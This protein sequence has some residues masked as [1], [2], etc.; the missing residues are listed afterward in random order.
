MMTNRR[1]NYILPIAFSLVFSIAI[2]LFVCVPSAAYA[3]LEAGNTQMASSEDDETLVDTSATTRSTALN[4]L[5]KRLDAMRSQLYVY[6]DFSDSLNHFTQKSMMWGKYRNCVKTPDENCK[7]KPH[8]GTSCI[9][10]AHDTSATDWGGWEFYN[11]GGKG[12]DLTGATELRFWARGNSGG[13]VIDFF[14]AGGSG[15]KAKTITKYSV[16]LTKKWKQYTISL[17]GANLGNIHRGFGYAINYAKNRRAKTTFYLDD[18]MFV[19]NIEALQEAP[20][21]LRSYDTST[22]QTRNAAF[23][24]DNALTAMAFMSAGRNG[25]AAEI[26]DAFVYAI[27]HDRY[28]AGRIRNAYAAGDISPTPGSQAG[29]RLPGWWDVGAQQWYEDATKSAA[30]SA[31]HRMRHSPSCITQR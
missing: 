24:Y 29:A 31:T 13:E 12:L 2:A 3:A 17:K 16:K 14:V 28:A 20:M 15:D 1:D 30:T 26:L 10:F 27:E 23:T 18:I 4:A 9:K 11:G 21:M 5:E 19:G 8:S 7:T 25:K 6:K 22:L